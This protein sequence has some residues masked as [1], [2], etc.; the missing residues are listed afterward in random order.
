MKRASRRCSELGVLPAL[1]AQHWVVFGE[2][3][4]VLF[5]AL[6]EPARAPAPDASGRVARVRE[7]LDDH[8]AAP[9]PL[10]ELTGLAGLSRF[11]LLRASP[12]RP[13]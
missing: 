4:L 3:L 7:R 12:K 6:L 9:H 2:R 1:A 10:A 11:Q 8:P 13:G 5:A